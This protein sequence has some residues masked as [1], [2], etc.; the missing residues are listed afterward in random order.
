MSAI[1]ESLAVHMQEGMEAWIGLLKTQSEKHGNGNLGWLLRLAQYMD[2]YIIAGIKENIVDF[3]LAKERSVA[4][5]NMIYQ[6]GFTEM[7]EAE[8]LRD[9]PPNFRRLLVMVE[10]IQFNNVPSINHELFNIMGNVSVTM[11]TDMA[12]IS[13]NIDEHIQH[14]ILDDDDPNE[15][16]YRLAAPRSQARANRRKSRSERLV[17]LLN[18]LESDPSSFSSAVEIPAMPEEDEDYIDNEDDEHDYSDNIDDEDEF[19]SNDSEYR[20]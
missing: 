15:A 14:T 7:Y 2:L 3:K 13:N 4:H 8:L 20:M 9:T 12:T 5:R 19:D 10:N 17:G 1:G 18:V 6:R 16:T 11:A